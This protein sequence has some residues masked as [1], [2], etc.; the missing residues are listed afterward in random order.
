MHPVIPHEGGVGKELARKI[1]DVWAK[2]A[3]RNGIAMAGFEPEAPLQQRIAWALTQGLKI[4]GILARQSTKMQNSIEVQACDNAAFAARDRL[5]PAPEYACADIVTGRKSGRQG[6]DRMRAI[7]EAKCVQVL[8]VYKVSRLFRSAHKGYAFIQENVVE[9]GLRAVSISQGIDTDNKETWKTLTLINGLS[10]EMLLTTIAD[11]VRSGL[12]SLFT[13]GFVVGALTVGYDAVEVPGGTPTK[14]GRPRRMPRVNSEVARFIIQAFE[15][16]RDGMPIRRAWRQWLANG[17]PSDRRSRS[18]VMSYVAFRRLLSNPRLTGRWAFGKRRNQWLSK[19]DYCS[20]IDVADTE[21]RVVISE[22]LRI[23]SDELYF[24]VQKRL[25]ELKKGPRGPKKKRDVQLWDVVTDC[26]FCAACSAGGELVRFYQ[27]G[28]AGEGMRCKHYTLCPCLTI[29]RRKEAVNAVCEKLAELLAQDAE[30]IERVVARARQI[31]AAGDET[32]QAELAAVQR[33]LMALQRKVDD[34]LELAGE[35][36]DEERARIKALV[37]AARAEAAGLEH[38]RAELRQALALQDAVIT[39]EQVRA[40]LEDLG[41]LLRDGAAGRLGADVVFRAGAVF[42]ALVG[43][44]IMVEVER[45]TSRKRSNVTGRFAP[46]LIRAVQAGLGDGRELSQS[47]ATE[48]RVWLRKPPRMDGLADRV[49]QLLDLKDHSY[50][51]AAKVL[52][53]AGIKINSGGVWQSYRR[54]YEMIGKPVPDRPYNNGRPREVHGPIS[55][56]PAT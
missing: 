48:A 40:V 30:L 44:R 11:H 51:S 33:K 20:Q 17:G 53:D 56:E 46:D 35:G 3:A 29:V 24:A 26:F 6:L 42:R 52:N 45:R 15:S 10:D 36:T 12:A 25:A 39:P 23:L 16:I 27:A 21:V 5:Y 1:H 50:R 22:E 14:L 4:A 28:A 32:V 18:S 19:K 47:A 37:R 8:L 31:D 41:A 13:Q 9:C 34:L 54:Y 2:E 38:R 55:Q 7:L 49:H 43:G